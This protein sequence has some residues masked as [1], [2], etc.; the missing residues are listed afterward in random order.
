MND[1]EKLAENANFISEM[2]K[3]RG[4]KNVQLLQADVKGAIPAVYGEV[5]TPGA[6]KTLIFYAHYDGQPVNPDKWAQGLSPF[7]PQLTT[8]SLDKGGQFMDFPIETTPLSN[9]WRLY[10]RAAA[11]DKAGVFTILNA[12][13]A[14]QNST[15]SRRVTHS[16]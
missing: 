11:D 14:I 8:N 9:D 10:A 16:R 5:L 2:M 12:Y 3:K 6:T 15:A 13:D 4:I 1:P 7:K